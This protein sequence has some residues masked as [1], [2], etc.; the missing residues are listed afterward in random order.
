MKSHKHHARSRCT[1][2]TSISKLT[3]VLVFVTRCPRANFAAKQLVASQLAVIVAL[4]TMSNARQVH[5]VYCSQ[6]VL[7]RVEARHWAH[8]KEDTSLSKHLL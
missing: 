6:T 7:A 4:L 2:S 3:Q 5:S 1:S 8:H